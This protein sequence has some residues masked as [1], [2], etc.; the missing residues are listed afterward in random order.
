MKKS[1]SNSNI[2]ARIL[3]SLI[4]AKVKKK[5]VVNTVYPVPH[6]TNGFIEFT[7]S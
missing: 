7:R 1:K 5:L 6:C 4:W 3:R 2:I